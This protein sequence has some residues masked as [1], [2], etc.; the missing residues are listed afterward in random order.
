MAHTDS[1]KIQVIQ[2]TKK[3]VNNGVSIR[4]ACQITEKE[5]DGIPAE[6][7]R[8]WWKET[9]EAEKQ[10]VKNDPSTETPT[11]S[12]DSEEIKRQPAK[13]GT[14][15][16]GPRPG[17]GR[18]MKTNESDDLL[19]DGSDDSE[20]SLDLFDDDP[21]EELYKEV[22]ENPEQEHPAEK[23]T[24]APQPK[25]EPSMKKE[26]PARA[27]AREEKRSHAMQFATIAIS[28]LSRIR[29]DDINKGNAFDKVKNWMEQNR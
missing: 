23:K 6:T 2:F 15:R 9:A 12:S 5:S 17:A 4:E 28:Q 10:W 19:I 21:V 14:M 24:D 25:E 11:A 3:L 26:S 22:T 20:K 18:K 16:G 7:V 1:C 27:R 13:D 29:K 8:R